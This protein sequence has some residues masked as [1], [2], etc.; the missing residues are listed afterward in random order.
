MPK[1]KP[2]RFSIATCISGRYVSKPGREY[3][4]AIYKCKESAQRRL[5]N[6]IKAYPHL[7][8]RFKVVEAGRIKFSLGFFILDY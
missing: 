6:I 2:L 8:G 1:K 7:T 3:S 5:R 4:A